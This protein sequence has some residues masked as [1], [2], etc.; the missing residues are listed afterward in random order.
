MKDSFKIFCKTEKEKIV[1][2]KEMEKRGYV[3]CSGEKPTSFNCG[4]PVG[5]CVQGGRISYTNEFKCYE[6]QNNLKSIT[7]DEFLGKSKNE[8]IVIYREDKEV[9]ALDKSTGKTAMAKCHPTDEFDFV[10]GAKLALDRLTDT[11]PEP[12]YFNGKAVCVENTGVFFTKGKI[13]E[14]VDGKSID[15]YGDRVPYCGSPIKSIDELNKGYSIAK[16]VEVVE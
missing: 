10:V 14:F 12:E 3:W 1:V 2:L 5:L 8:C 6:R 7:I 13:Y 15:D 11:A 4:L 9:I 16:F